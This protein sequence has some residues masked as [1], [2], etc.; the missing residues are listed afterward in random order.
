MEAEDIKKVVVLGAGVMGH[1]IAMTCA[2]N[3]IGTMMVDVSKDTLEQ[4]Y[5]QMRNGR[6]G[7]TKLVEKGKMTKEDM[8]SLI[9]KIGA[10]T[11]IEE[12][13]ENADLIIEA[14]AEDLELK[15]KVWKQYD[16]ICSERTIFAS[17]TS[18][19]MITEQAAATD[20]PDRFIGMHWFNPAQI[21]KLIEVIRGALTST[22]TFNVTIDFSR[23]LGKNPLEAKDAP[24][25]FTSR[26]IS[27][28]MN[29][30]VRMFEEGIAGIEEIDT[31]CKQA[32]G[33]PMGPFELLDH[34]GL[35]VNVHSSDYIYGI[36]GDPAA[37]APVSL[38]KLAAAGY[39]GNKAMSKGGWY[40]YYQISKETT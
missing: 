20:R 9:S 10:T 12:A 11:D 23:K 18:T 24:G 28:V 34:T 36:T 15:K 3:G 26:F 37:K 14:I 38:R 16:K 2:R 30:A 1:G 17:N 13:A 6:F 4:A 19:I 8:E 5:D 33:F 7:L 29:S 32:F 27:M 25:F 31:M 39:L 21:M 35:D 40:D 22:E